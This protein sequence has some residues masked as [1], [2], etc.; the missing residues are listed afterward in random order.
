MP[1][2]VKHVTTDQLRGDDVRGRVLLSWLDALKAE[3]PGSV[4]SVDEIF[5]FF[6]DKTSELAIHNPHYRQQSRVCKGGTDITSIV[7]SAELEL[8][9]RLILYSKEVWTSVL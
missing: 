6:R 1:W 2:S 5:Y 7:R 3:K 9:G 8:A 4:H